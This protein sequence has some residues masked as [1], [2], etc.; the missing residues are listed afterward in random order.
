M[1]DNILKY[2]LIVSLLMNFSL[3]GAAAY[4]HYRQTHFGPPPFAGPVGFQGKPGP[5]G[6]P[7][8]QPGCLFQELS[9]K[10]E[11]VKLFQQ[12]ALIFH[13]DLDKKRQE[14]DR[15]RGSLIAL[16][17][18]DKPDNKEIDA[19]ISRINGIQEDMQKTVVSHMLEFKSMLNKDQQKKFLDLIQSATGQ[20]GEEAVCP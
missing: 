5:F 14:V 2:I 18:A 12:K 19:T 4:T 9:L 10:P 3:L 8:M 6:P 15:L 20:R 1:R 13:Q 7:G 11:Q 16:M 17:R